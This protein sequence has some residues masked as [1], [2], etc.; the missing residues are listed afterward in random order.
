MRKE[1]I[2]IMG[3]SFNPPTVAHLK[4][5]QM[6]LDAFQGDRGYFVPVSFPYLKRKMRKKEAG[7]FCLP[8][9]LRVRMLE[10]M[11]R[12]DGRLAVSELELKEIQVVTY[13]TMDFFAR[14]N[15][16]AR[17]Y[18]LVGADK[19]DMVEKWG[20][21]G[22]FLERFGV[23][24]FGRDAFSQEQQIEKIKKQQGKKD[25]FLFLQQPEEIR[26]IS[27]T[28][29]RRR[30]LAGE[31]V[32]G[33]L[34]PEVW[35]QMKGLKPEDFPEEIDA[36]KGKYAFLDNGYPV[37]VVWEELTYTSAEAAFQ[38]SKTK[39][40][41]IRKEFAGCGLPK[42]KQ[43]GARLVPY[44]GWEE[45]RA[46][47]MEEIL[48]QKFGQNPEL[49]GKLA[50]TGRKLLIAGNNGKDGFWGVDLY[51]WQGEN[52]LGKLL[53]KLREEIQARADFC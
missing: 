29:V 14:E 47:I 13:H 30:F 20:E 44:D 7:N 22:D 49:A 16:E 18:F 53:M 10:K 27:S 21:E 17:C 45:K 35:E 36:F 51:N 9:S 48:R 52:H 34:C 39:D 2:V 4:I 12:I 11:F 32:S 46:E 25:S 42:A 15:P 6:A 19:L 3:G 31:D 1:K 37:E 43:K 41:R 28:E 38:A 5:M 24:A 50:D 26:L 33:Y 23:I 40:S 8:D